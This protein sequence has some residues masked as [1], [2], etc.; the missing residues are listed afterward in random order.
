MNTIL[1]NI[2]NQWKAAKKALKPPLPTQPKL[3]PEVLVGPIQ[4]SLQLQQDL[5]NQWNDFYLEEI[6]FLWALVYYPN[7]PPA[8]PPK[9]K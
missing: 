6:R 2:Q 4:N 5:Q 3:P 8:S 7:Q 1:G 9:A